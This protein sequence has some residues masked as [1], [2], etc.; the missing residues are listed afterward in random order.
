MRSDRPAIDLAD[1]NFP[2]AALAGSGPAFSTGD[3]FDE[4]MSCD[5]VESLMVFL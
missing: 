4:L 1:V 5:C 2:L 3:T